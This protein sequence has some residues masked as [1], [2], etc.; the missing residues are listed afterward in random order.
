MK[1]FLIKYQFGSGS[2]EAWHRQIAQFISALDN[3][4]D[5]RGKISYRCMRG[6]DGTS[7]YHLAAASDAQ[8]IS[9]LQSKDWFKRYTEET[10][11]VAAG[12]VEVLP[13]EII[14][15]TAGSIRDDLST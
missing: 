3:D 6:K 1:H 13:L 14:A 8:A 5:L 15:E 9:A 2:T 11:M 10:R 4:P 7:Y 12:A